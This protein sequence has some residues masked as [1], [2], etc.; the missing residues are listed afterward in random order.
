[1]AA[2]GT[3]KEQKEMAA[4]KDIWT[5]S[6]QLETNIGEIQSLGGIGQVNSSV[7]GAA[8]PVGEEGKIRSHNL[9]EVGIAF[10]EMAQQAITLCD[11]IS[12]RT[13]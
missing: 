10:L 11:P 4:E 13:R 2:Q 7:H 12:E 9:S 3:G 5:S 1:M 6:H 8:M